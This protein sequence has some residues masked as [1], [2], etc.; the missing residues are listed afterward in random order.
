MIISEPPV[1]HPTAIDAACKQM[2]VH[3]QFYLPQ[4]G[5]PSIPVREWGEREL[6]RWEIAS[7]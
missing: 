5:G 4:I 3:G 7:A 6:R 2:W 1:M